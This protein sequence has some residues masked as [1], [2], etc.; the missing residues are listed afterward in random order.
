MISFSKELGP[1]RGRP[2]RSVLLTVQVLHRNMKSKQPGSIVV[3][4][5]MVLTLSSLIV[6]GTLV[7]TIQMDTEMI[8]TESAASESSK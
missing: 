3:E 8:A 6:F 2:R 7:T 1:V 4:I 5:A